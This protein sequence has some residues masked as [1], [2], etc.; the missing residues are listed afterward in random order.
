MAVVG[1]NFGGFHQNVFNSGLFKA[2]EVKRKVKRANR[3]Y[4]LSGTVSVGRLG[5]IAPVVVAWLQLK[6]QTCGDCAFYEQT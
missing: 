1:K 6:S 5:K 3:V 2:E 4:L